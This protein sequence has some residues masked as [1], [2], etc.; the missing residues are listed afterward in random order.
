MHEAAITHSIMTSVMQTLEE[1]YVTG[2]VTHVYVTVGVT[3]GIVPDSMQMF[4]DMEKTGTALEHAVLII[5]T[6]GI[7]GRCGE[8]DAEHA[9]DIPIMY[10]PDCAS[11]MELIKGNEIIISSIEV[12]D[13]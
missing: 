7:V 12:E 11:P 10:C 9:L 2:T 6:Q 8:C 3:Q 5:E 13:E 4:F 1:Q